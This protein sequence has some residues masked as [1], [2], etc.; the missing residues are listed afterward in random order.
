MTS[1]SS[2]NPHFLTTIQ[3]IFAADHAMDADA[4]VKMLTEDSSM[5]IGGNITLRGREAIRQAVAGLFAQFSEISHALVQAYDQ[6]NTLIYEAEVTYKLKSSVRIS[7][8]YVNILRFEGDLIGDYRI[9]I[10]MSPIMH[11]TVS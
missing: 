6:S 11:S 2:I 3:S 1:P 4:F 8:P 7:C 5:R 10:D 9:Y